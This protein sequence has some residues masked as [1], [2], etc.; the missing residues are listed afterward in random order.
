MHNI[1][2]VAQATG[3]SAHTIRAW[4][5]RYTALSPDRTVT[6][7]RL[8]TNEDVDKLRL[9]S[10]GLQAGHSIG[11]IAHL[12]LEELVELLPKEESASEPQQLSTSDATAVSIASFLEQ[13]S[14]AIDEMEGTALADTLT[15]ASAVL[16]TAQ[17]IDRLL[18]PLLQNIGERW[19]DGSVR[20]S[21]EHMASAIIRT[22]LGRT[23]AA[24]QPSTA[25]P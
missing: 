6:N 2:Y 3:L 18:I 13:C 17:L 9:L 24:F 7:R 8:Y 21:Q 25:A 20:I 1:K 12:S 22:Y 10:R 4:E 14:H 16:G 19:R 5:R 23:L 15:R 11:R